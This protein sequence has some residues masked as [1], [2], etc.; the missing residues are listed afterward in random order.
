MTTSTQDMQR[1]LVA[2]SV[3]TFF[4]LFV[5]ITGVSDELK[6]RTTFF[7]GKQTDL[8][9][10]FPDFSQYNF[11][12]TLSTEE[13]P[14]RGKHDRIITVGDIHGRNDTLRQDR[15]AIFF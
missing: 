15:H 5:F 1:S 3:I 9:T 10:S 13:F 14:I 2:G 7:G 4:L 6:R 12:R 11:L 8:D